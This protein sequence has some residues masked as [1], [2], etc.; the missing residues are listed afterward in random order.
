[1]TADEQSLCDEASNE[2]S[3]ATSLMRRKT[4]L[5]F[6]QKGH[7]E[8]PQYSEAQVRV[9]FLDPLWN[10][11]GWDVANE[12]RLLPQVREVVVEPP[13]QSKEKKGRA[14]YGF[15]V[16]NRFIFMVEAKK[17][18]VDVDDLDAI[19]QAKMYAWCAKCPVVVLTNFRQ[20][21][22][23][24]IDARPKR[25]RP[26]QGRLERLCG[27]VEDEHSYVKLLQSYF[28]RSAVI[29]QRSLCE[30]SARA[31][32]D[33]SNRYAVDQEF[34]KSLM[35][36]RL[37]IGDLLSS[38]INDLDDSELDYQSQLLLDRLLF[39]RVAEERGIPLLHSTSIAGIAK[40][41]Q[42]G[43]SD[44]LGA[45]FEQLRQDYNGNVFAES[46]LDRATLNDDR[47]HAILTELLP[48]E[49]EYRLDAFP[50]DFLGTVYERYMGVRLVRASNSVRLQH[51]PERIRGHGAHYTP[52][53]IV[54]Y[55]VEQSLGRWLWQGDI[56]TKDERADEARMEARRWR[57]YQ[58]VRQRRVLDPACGSGAFLLA[59][60]DCLL[61][62]Y[63]ERAKWRPGDLGQ[64]ERQQLFVLREGEVVESRPTL[65]VQI[66]K[67]HIF[68]IDIDARA[69][70]VATLSLYLRIMEGTGSLFPELRLPDLSSNLKCGNSLV[71]PATFNKAALESGADPSD[72]DL[73]ERINPWSPGGPNGYFSDAD[74]GRFE[75]V[76]GN[77]PYVFGEYLDPVEKLAY[78]HSLK[79]A[80]AGQADL[81][82]LFYERTLETFLAPGGV[83]AFIVP[84]ALLARDEH[85]EIRALV[86][87]YLDI[88]R[89]LH[90]GQVFLSVGV[91]P[92][93]EPQKVKRVGVSSVVVIGHRRQGDRSSEAASKA[94]AVDTRDGSEFSLSHELDRAVI[95]DTAGGPWNIAAPA[96]WF[97]ENGLRARME[98]ASGPLENQLRSGTG[99][100]TRGEELGKSSLEACN[101]PTQLS[102]GNVQIYAGENASRHLLGPP[103]KQV[104]ADGVKKSPEYYRGPKILFVKTGAGPVAAVSVDDI[105]A[106]QS[107]YVL[108]TLN[109][110]IDAVHGI[111]AVLCS[112]VVTAYSFYKWT[113]GKLLQPQFTIGNLRSMP[114]PNA[115]GD[116]LVDVGRE[117]QKIGPLLERASQTSI[118]GRR[119]STLEMAAEMELRIDRL[120]A[121][122]FGLDLETE[123]AV[124]SPAL[125][126][127]PRSQRP[128]WFH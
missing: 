33:I 46:L 51:C 86:V 99:G 58:Y 123:L 121:I 73:I 93:G 96:M 5:Y 44:R 87:E 41:G 56:P 7:F 88:T 103:T 102:P 92:D 37:K 54:R 18:A 62:W 35:S 106:L 125:R 63:L 107:V 101:G 6:S 55:M 31:V 68:G 114:F 17:P 28:C 74:E 8:G 22:T 9:D 3:N 48:P 20:F 34:L 124:I 50:P 19:Y 30:L 82:K 90:A 113:S 117:A 89:F 104:R 95:L 108:H 59:A 97:G 40:V 29:G 52:H 98:G 45:M 16:E 47:L 38:S 84:D 25:L 64:K 109:E 127:L 60:F 10:A 94:I 81:Y 110:D 118:P 78:R 69:V 57:T 24:V 43:V 76:V 122:A 111:C 75:F 49:L 79:L 66:V 39:A 23:Y 53:S 4:E 91:G 126:S 13:I 70:E 1:M 32:V 65:K 77:P 112:A 83:H 2:E 15:R 36:I 105:P 61:D 67:D 128:R 119:Q 80:Q 27:S 100:S 11:L 72:L 85:A 120:V 14:D 21:R 12:R 42:E 71:E 115:P 116:W 26:R